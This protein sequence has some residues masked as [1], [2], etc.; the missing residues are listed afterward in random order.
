MAR[1]IVLSEDAP[2]PRLRDVLMD[3]TVYPIHLDDEHCAEQLVQRLA[4]AISGQTVDH[5]VPTM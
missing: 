4:W 5:G 1:L 3:E 2:T